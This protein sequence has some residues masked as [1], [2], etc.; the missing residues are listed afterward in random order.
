MMNSGKRRNRRC[1]KYIYTDVYGLEGTDTFKVYL[2]GAPV[3]IC[4]RKSISGCVQQMKM[5]QKER[6]IH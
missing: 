3:R 1:V 4:Q 5:V 2:P 6:R